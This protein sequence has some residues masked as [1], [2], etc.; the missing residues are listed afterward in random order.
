ME[1]IMPYI[2]DWKLDGWNCCIYKL[3]RSK[4]KNLKKIASG[5]IKILV[6]NSGDIYLDHLYSF[7]LDIVDTKLSGIL[8]LP[9]VIETLPCNIQSKK[10]IPMVTYQLGNIVCYCYNWQSC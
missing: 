5:I 7:I 2:H 9:D 1:F 10:N 3:N 8:N 4:K 6:D